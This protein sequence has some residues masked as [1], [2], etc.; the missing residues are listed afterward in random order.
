MTAVRTRVQAG[1]F[2]VAA[3]SQ[4]ILIL[5]RFKKITVASVDQ[6]AP[7]FEAMNIAPEKDIGS[8]HLI[9]ACIL[10]AHSNE[11]GVPPGMFAAGDRALIEFCRSQISDEIEPGDHDLLIQ[12]IIHSWKLIGAH[13]LL[14]KYLKLDEFLQTEGP[15]CQFAPM[16][17]FKLFVHDYYAGCI[18]AFFNNRAT[19]LDLLKEWTFL[20]FSNLHGVGVRQNRFLKSELFLEKVTKILSETGNRR[21]Q[22]E[23][24]LANV[25]KEHEMFNAMWFVTVRDWTLLEL[26]EIEK[27]PGADVGLT[28]LLEE[29]PSTGLSV[30]LE[31]QLLELRVQRFWS[32]ET[33]LCPLIKHCNF[34]QVSSTVL[35]SNQLMKEV[36]V[37]AICTYAHKNKISLYPV[38]LVQPILLYRLCGKGKRAEEQ[39]MSGLLDETL[40]LTLSPF[41]LFAILNKAENSVLKECAQQVIS[42]RAKQEEIFSVMH[43]FNHLSIG[44]LS[45]LQGMRAQPS[46]L[47]VQFRRLNRLV[48]APPKSPMIDEEDA[49]AKSSEENPADALYEAQNLENK[50]TCS[51]Q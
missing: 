44:S 48:N 25:K 9:N 51:I 14:K 19:S 5:N 35:T 18:S 33:M 8:E 47:T 4:K 40:S 28:D 34:S 50:R 11:L 41:E 15:E 13:P 16:G 12:E 3:S 46:P 22:V 31:E 49:P 26:D 36:I 10:Y 23:A 21:E 32:S 2:A 37:Y 39:V 27:L 29:Q 43:S 1:C 7:L 30:E 42:A 45:V 24:F 6:F 17:A 38:S 20:I